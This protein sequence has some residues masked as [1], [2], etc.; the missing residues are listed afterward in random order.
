MKK[1]MHRL[2]LFSE[3]M[4]KEYHAVQTFDNVEQAMKQY[5]YIT[6]E[7]LDPSPPEPKLTLKAQEKMHLKCRLLKSSTANNC[8][9]LLTN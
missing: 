9:T 4:Q 8:P 6:G 3:Q 2:D 7:H 5:Y 1:R